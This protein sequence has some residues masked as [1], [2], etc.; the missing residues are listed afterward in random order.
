M[1]YEITIKVS[2]P[3]LS[4]RLQTVVTVSG[5]LFDASPS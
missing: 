3:L 2:E 1:E 5:A 4:L